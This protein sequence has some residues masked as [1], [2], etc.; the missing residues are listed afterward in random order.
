MVA[1]LSS[2]TEVESADEGSLPVGSTAAEDAVEVPAVL[3]AWLAAS[4]LALVP[5][6]RWQRLT[7]GSSNLTYR[8]TDGEGRRCVLRRP[9][10]QA[11]RNTHDVL[12]ESRI[13]DALGGSGLPVASVRGSC[14]DPGIIGAPFYVMSFVEGTVLTSVQSAAA[15][16]EAYRAAVSESFVAALATLHD[17]DPEQIGLDGLARSDG[18]IERQLNRWI[19]QYRQSRTQDVPLIEDIH[20]RLKSRV[21]CDEHRGIV[22]GD[23]RLENVMFDDTGQV[24]AVLDWELATLGETSTDLAWALLYWTSNADEAEELILTRATALPGFLSRDDMVARYVLLSGRSLDD[25][26]FY[27]AFACWRASCIAEGVLS[28]YVHGQMSAQGVDLAKHARAV[29]ARAELADELLRRA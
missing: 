2:G 3:A 23:F 25:L 12:R 7:G 22:H 10:D 28:R 21:P 29:R 20:S 19:G 11:A 26:N 18:Y 17:I 15:T 6:V 1:S 8:L 14:A 9:P 5:P 27:L 4:D 24:S 13:V 16:T